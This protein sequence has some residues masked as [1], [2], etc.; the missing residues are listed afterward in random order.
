MIV[1]HPA[2]CIRLPSRIA[3]L[4]SMLLLIVWAAGCANINHLREA[5]DA[6]NQ[7]AAAENALRFES[8]SPIADSA[9]AAAATWSSARNS[10]SSALLSIEKLASGDEQRLRANGL[11]GTTLTL[12][13]ISQWR[14]GMSD[15]ALATVD[16]ARASAS[17]QINPRDQA[18]LLALPG[19]IKS[20]QAY[21]KIL[22]Q[23]PLAEVEALLI[24][25]NGAVVNMEAARASVDRDHPVNLYLLQS[26]LTAYRNFMVAK[27]RL[28]NHAAIPPDH[29]ARAQANAALKELNRLLKSQDAG[30]EGQKLIQYWVRLCALDIPQ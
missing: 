9:S 7:A 8:T 27:D 12:K 28:D 15:K 13:A 23:R 30:P 4:C 3:V 1:K 14:L 20:D 6:F 19:L 24:G 26:E 16:E 29:P 11:W 22:R 5:Q 21:D 17:D 10:Y 18:L 2:N 25:S